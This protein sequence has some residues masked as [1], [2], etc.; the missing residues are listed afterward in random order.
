LSA[1]EAKALRKLS[2]RV[3]AVMRRFLDQWS[4][5]CTVESVISFGPSETTLVS[6]EA[7]ESA[8][9]VVIAA[10]D[11]ER[12]YVALVSGADGSWRLP[13][14][15]RCAGESLVETALREVEEE[16]GLSGT[17]LS[18]GPY[19][20]CFEYNEFDPTESKINHFYLMHVPQGLPALRT[21]SAHE[22]AMWALLPASELSFAYRY[23]RELLGE[24]VS[25]Y[26]LENES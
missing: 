11:V 21:D 12:H 7:V 18:V 3:G 10:D 25:S 19:L 1:I 16:T 20:G 22:E 13:K 4:F 15:H 17:Q 24:I 26:R 8:G 6:A 5:G 23:Q 14:G 9:G 2:I